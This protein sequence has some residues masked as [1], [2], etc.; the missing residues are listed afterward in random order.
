MRK[1]MVKVRMGR[2][3]GHA[4]VRTVDRGI[5]HGEVVASHGNED[6]GL[7]RGRLRK[8]HDGKTVEVLSRLGPAT[9]YGTPIQAPERSKQVL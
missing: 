1:E 9:E 7:G 3:G 5:G 4:A 8:S 6:S 2:R